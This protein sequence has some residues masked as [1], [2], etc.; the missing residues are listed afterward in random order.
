[1]NFKK[2][3]NFL[4]G[5][6]LL[7]GSL[8][9]QNVCVST[10]KTSLVLSAPEGGTLR[11]LY[12]GNRLSEA[13]L[14]NISAAEANHAAYP[15]YGLNAPVETALAVKHADGNMTL[16]LEVLNVTTEKEGNAVTTVVALKDKVYPFFVNV[17]YRAW[18]DA[19]VIESWTAIHRRGGW[20]DS[21]RRTD[22]A[23][24]ASS[25]DGRFQT[26]ILSRRHPARHGNRR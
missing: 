9:A 4:F 1:M 12:Y 21:R 5:V 15:E 10:P 24:P 20:A 7:T 26:R 18:Q 19:D 11:H 8:L 16:Q 2:R 3:T 22:C 13:D 23:P 14:Q 25:P 6:L 17:C